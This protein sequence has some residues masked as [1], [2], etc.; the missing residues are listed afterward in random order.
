MNHPAEAILIDMLAQPEGVTD[1]VRRHLA[2]CSACQQRFDEL[3]LVHD[4]L[5]DEPGADQVEAMAGVD[6]WPGLKQRLAAETAPEPVIVR[7]A[8]NWWA[9]GTAWRA[10]A[11]VMLS[12]GIGHLTA[13]ITAESTTTTTT[14]STATTAGQTDA[15]TVASAED[16]VAADL[17]LDRFT[18]SS[19]LGLSSIVLTDSA[20]VADEVSP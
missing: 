11:L 6:L 13:R 7:R 8:Q 17:Y 14:V 1:D 4:L 15:T 16:L 9:S 2:E 5:G 20:D 3:R 10:A 18:A 19:P 12:I